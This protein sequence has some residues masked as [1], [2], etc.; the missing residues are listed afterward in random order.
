VS[1]RI[2]QGVTTR[3]LQYLREEGIS[4]ELPAVTELL[5]REV[6]RLQIITIMT[7][8]PLPDS[9]QV[10]LTATLQ[11]KWGNYDTSFTV[12]PSILSGMIIAFRDQVIDM[13]G[14]TAMT[15]LKQHLA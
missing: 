6:D 11:E 8:A 10:E 5:Q 7:A 9:E 13:S 12:D 3:L 1:N 15:D 4:E 2:A 14:R